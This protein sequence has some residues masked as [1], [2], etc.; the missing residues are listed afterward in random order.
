MSPLRVVGIALLAIGLLEALVAVA[1]VGPRIQDPV[2]KRFL[3]TVL[4]GGGLSSALL[5]LAFALG[6]VGA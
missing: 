3:V 5:G 2:K 6:L 4:L 1:V